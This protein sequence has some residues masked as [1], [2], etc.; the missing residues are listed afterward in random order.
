LAL[1]ALRERRAWLE[2]TAIIQYL[3][4]LLLLAAGAARLIQPQRLEMAG[5]A[6]AVMQTH[7]RNLAL[8]LLVKATTAALVTELPTLAVAVAAHLLLVKMLRLPARVT[9]ARDRLAVSAARL[10]A[11]PV[12]VAA[13]PD[14]LA[15]FPELLHKAAALV[16]EQPLRERLEL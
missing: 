4:L 8:E 13:V 5:L 1:A 14:Q 3:A 11:M 6:A 10:W 2:P 15:Q 12:A 7:L 16:V 9:A